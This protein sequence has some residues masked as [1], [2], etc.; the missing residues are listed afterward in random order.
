MG[1]VLDNLD[2][3]GQF[4][5][6]LTKADGTV[7]V[8]EKHNLVVT[9]GLSFALKSIF[10]SAH[11][12]KM[13]HIA[14][15]SGTTVPSADDTALGAEIAR[16]PAVV[17]VSGTTATLVAN[18]PVGVGTGALT[19]AGIFSAA[20]GGIMFDRVTFSVKNKDEGDVFTITFTISCSAE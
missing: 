6:V 4:R 8:V 20:S 11:V 3:K 18:L 16:I 5:G 9:S 2:L 1:R 17:S 15:G 19:E 14:V 10:D 12:L 7:E 13:T